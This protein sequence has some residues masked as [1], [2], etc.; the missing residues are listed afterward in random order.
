[1]EI[2]L[3]H[4]GAKL[5]QHTHDCVEQ[6][7]KY[8]KENVV[9]L[10]DADTKIV[11]GQ[12]V[13]VPTP[14]D[15]FLSGFWAHTLNR[16]KVLSDYMASN[17][18]EDVIHIENDVL[19]Y[20]DPIDLL[21][22][23]RAISKDRVLITALGQSHL[24]AAYMYIPHKKAIGRLCDV[25]Y[26][27]FSMGHEE[28]KAHIGYSFVSEMTVLD[29]IYKKHDAPIG[30]L[31]IMPNDQYLDLFKAVFDPASYGQY[32]GGIQTNPGVNWAGNHHLIGKKINK[33]ELQ[34]VFENGKPYVI[35]GDT[36]WPI[37]NL[38]I[39]SKDLKRWM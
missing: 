4:V 13:K 36:R 8:S 29:H 2:V 26:E 19:I 21:D 30:L 32:I 14:N 20:H 34:P 7:V 25:M 37:N 6:I 24:S 17:S 3:V 38:H 28:L 5:P 12:V 33:G 10:T 35:G 1:M 27:H 15:T 22:I 23:F 39:H 16:L 18:T 9:L 31:P 11:G